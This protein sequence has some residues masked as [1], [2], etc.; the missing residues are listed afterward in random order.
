MFRLAFRAMAAQTRPTD[1]DRVEAVRL[2]LHGLAMGEDHDSI[3]DRLG[4]LHLP[5][6]TFPAEVLLELAAEAIAESG[7]TQVEPI[8]YEGIRER[9]LPEYEFRGKS[10]QHKS[11]YALMAAAMIRAGIYPDLLDEAYG[12]GIED[13]WRY[14]FYAL[15]AYARAASERTGRSLEEIAATLAEHRALTLEAK[16]P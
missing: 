8:E 3:T 16:T 1:E 5:N 9:N 13:M 6:N 15:V 11:H 2:V 7:A 14:A 10:G 12:W 4:Q